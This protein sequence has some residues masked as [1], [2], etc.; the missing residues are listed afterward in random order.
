MKV[1]L[2]NRKIPPRGEGG[3]VALRVESSGLNQI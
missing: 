1:T 3:D 2:I